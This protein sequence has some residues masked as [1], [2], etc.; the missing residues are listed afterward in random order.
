MAISTKKKRDSGELKQNIK[1]T[2][3]CPLCGEKF[4]INI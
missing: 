4:E 1:Q 2:Q 3:V